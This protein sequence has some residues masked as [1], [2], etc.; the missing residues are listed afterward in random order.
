MLELSVVTVKSPKDALERLRVQHD[1]FDLV[2]T[3][4]HMPEMNGIELQKQVDEEFK[5]PVIS[6]CH[7]GLKMYFFNFKFFDSLRGLNEP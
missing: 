2:V 7:F 5:L 1:V 4:L 3:D 6:K